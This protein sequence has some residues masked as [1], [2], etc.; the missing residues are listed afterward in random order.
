MRWVCSS[1]ASCGVFVFGRCCAAVMRRLQE[2]LGV[3]LAGFCGGVCD[4]RAET[5]HCIPHRRTE[6][7]PSCHC[8]TVFQPTSASSSSSLSTHGLSAPLM[9]IS[10]KHKQSFMSFND[11]ITFWEITVI[12]MHT[13]INDWLPKRICCARVELIAGRPGIIWSECSDVRGTDTRHAIIRGSAGETL[14]MFTKTELQLDNKSSQS[15]CYLT[16]FACGVV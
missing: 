6:I 5:S 15:F 1:D 14:N 7:A 3:S 8:V 13:R 11:R 4:V 2:K 10:L 16:V 12:H 9:I